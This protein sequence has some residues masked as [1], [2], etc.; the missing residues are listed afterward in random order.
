MSWR[1]RGPAPGGEEERCLH[2]GSVSLNGEKHPTG[3]QF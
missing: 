2:I 3:K 1:R